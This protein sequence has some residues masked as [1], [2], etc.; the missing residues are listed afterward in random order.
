MSVGGVGSCAALAPPQPAPSV[1]SRR[2]AR[3]ARIM[4]HFTILQRVASAS[5]PCPQPHPPPRWGRDGWGW[6]FRFARVPLGAARYS[7][8]RIYTFLLSSMWRT[9]GAMLYSM[10]MRTW[11]IAIGVSALLSASAGA[12]TWICK[13]PD[14]TKVF[15]DS[16]S[17]P[18]CARYFP[19]SELGH[20]AGGAM[21]EQIGRAHV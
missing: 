17:G 13:Q 6:L 8:S 5:R 3:I 20:A 2:E 10:P 15:S 21:G 18:N 9:S 4:T 12:E 16:G 19:K 14:G 11:I 7:S 1:R